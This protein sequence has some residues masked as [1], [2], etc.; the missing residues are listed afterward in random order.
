MTPFFCPGKP[1]RRVILTLRVRILRALAPILVRVSSGRSAVD[2]IAAVIAGDSAD[3]V[4]ARMGV[5]IVRIAA[6]TVTVVVI[7]A[8]TG[9]R[10]A[11]RVGG[12]IVG[13]IAAGG[14]SSAPL[15]DMARI[16][17]T[18]LPPRRHRISEF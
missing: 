13:G 4:D 2:A 8:R 10:I 5:P 15:V 16:A 14:A 12:R 17:G 3:A 18:L 7:V 1:V 11:A 6:A 9:A